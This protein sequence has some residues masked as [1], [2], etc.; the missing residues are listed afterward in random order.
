[1]SAPMYCRI[2]ILLGYQHNRSLHL[3]LKVLF[4][5]LINSETEGKNI[6]YTFNWNLFK[7]KIKSKFT[8]NKFNLKPEKCASVD[9]AV[10]RFCKWNDKSN[11]PIV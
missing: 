10:C 5:S 4:I 9:K 11:R 7:H 8:K 2:R 6:D 3:T 1:M